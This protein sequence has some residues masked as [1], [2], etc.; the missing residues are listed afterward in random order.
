MGAK[1]GALPQAVVR[2]VCEGP[3]ET[4]GGLLDLERGAPKAHGHKLP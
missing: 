3:E 1:G 2:R 4:H